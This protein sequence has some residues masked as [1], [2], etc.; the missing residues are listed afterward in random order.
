MAVQAVVV[1]TALYNCAIAVA[2]SCIV[3]LI[4][5]FL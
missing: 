4:H 1:P 5:C 2:L 3:K